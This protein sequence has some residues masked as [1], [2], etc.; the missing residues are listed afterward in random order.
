M[1]V[2]SR[3]YPAGAILAALALAL[4]LSAC[5]SEPRVEPPVVDTAALIQ[6]ELEGPL[7]CADPYT[8]TS[9][10][11]R[12]VFSDVVQDVVDTGAIAG[13]EIELVDSAGIWIG[14][15][16]QAADGDFGPWYRLGDLSLN[17]RDRR[18]TFIA[19]A[20]SDSA[21]FTGTISCMRLHGDLRAFDAE[22]GAE[23]MLPRVRHLWDEPN[24]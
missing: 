20:D 18:I 24:R 23:T 21:R 3:P 9:P 19:P 5:R 11:T 13:M 16:H 14:R 7:A 8:D 2:P 1:L 22:I 12:M 17:P 15:Y 4:L 10:A 6:S